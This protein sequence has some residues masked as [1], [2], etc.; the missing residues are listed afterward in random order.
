MSEAKHMLSEED[1]KMRYITPAIQKSGWDI[2]RQVRSEYSFTDGRIIVRGKLVVR[3]KRKR[4]DYLLD[5]KPNIPLA[6]IEAK[7]NIKSVRA[8]IQQGIEYAEILDVPFIYSSNGDGFVEHDRF[9][10]QEK[11]LNLTQFPSPEELW[12]RYRIGK[13]L[14]P[15]QEEIVKE[16]YY[17]EMG[18][19]SPRYYQ[20]VAVNRT[21]EAIA[22]GQNRIL[23]VMATG[24]GKTY[25][26]FQV[27]YRLWKSRAKKRILFLA[28][29]NILV[30][31]TM[32]NDFK[33]FADKMVKVDR[34]NISKAHEVYLALY[35]SMT[36]S[37]DWQNI[38]K[39]FSPDFFDLVVVDECHR[40]SAKENSAWREVLAYFDG[41]TQIGMTATP[42]ETK[43]VS[44][45]T[46]FGE[47]VYTYSLKQGIDD[48][49][50][51]P[52]KVVRLTL[53]R[54]LG[55]RPTIGQKDKYG[56]SIEDREYLAT[57]YD[58]NLIMEKRIEKV[59]ETITEFL[60]GTNRYDKTIVFC[61]DIEHA[62]NMRQALINLNADLV[63]ENSKYVMKITGDDQEGKSQL[64]NFIDPGSR[65]PVI[66]TTS[67]L[68]T[69]GVDAQTC[70]VVVLDSNINSMT[71][72]K[73]IIGRGTRINEAYGKQYFT[74]LDFRNATRLF[75][76]P[77][78]DG[79]PEVIYEPPPGEPPIPPDELEGESEINENEEPYT[80]G[81]DGTI[82]DPPEPKQKYYVDN[83]EVQIVHKRVEYYDKDGKLITES[84]V[85]Y[86]KKNLKKEYATLDEFIRKWKEEEKKTAIV[87]ELKEQGVFLKEVR[88]EVGKELDD[89]DII[90]HLAF[91]QKPLTRQER[92]NNVKKRNYFGKYSGVAKQVLEALLEKYMDEGVSELENL[93]VLNLDP[94]RRMGTPAKL[95]KE[96]GGREQY[97]K[98]IRELEKEIYKDI[99]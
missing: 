76:D 18:G 14:A 29:R 37:E 11:E 69:T 45:S 84:L 64:D 94:F 95:V 25:T 83:V 33:H 36:G 35:Q 79:E 93:L 46:Y 5:Y 88:E 89:F 82:S 50:L 78:F 58:R 49:F 70:K 42:K 39:Q 66:A 41:A 92:A 24:T 85:D 4:A 47:P 98:T 90:L 91:D 65:Y 34:R 20:R 48:G 23:L 12:Q 32:S 2:H 72:F 19:K 80:T 17:F 99:S 26:A 16:D 3:G 15:E 54:D 55:W 52:Y 75:A 68:M 27:I 43:D 59:A 53:D 6:I 67:K 96:F 9:T 28:D 60:N 73:Q 86:T 62:E 56:N 87:E 81:D 1:I 21:V 22:K 97:L 63:K 77:E 8:G 57:D 71:E 38:Y 51:A 44:S 10:G 7:D 30:D 13:G 31:Q 74:I 40:G 61:V